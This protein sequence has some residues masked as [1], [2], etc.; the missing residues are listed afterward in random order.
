MN[1]LIKD[2]VIKWTKN[3]FRSDFN[4]RPGQLEAIVQ[5]IDDKINNSVYHHIA[6]A[7]TGSGKS[8]INN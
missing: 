3:K 2:Q 4:F 1:E 7:P 5:I 6:Q 8:L